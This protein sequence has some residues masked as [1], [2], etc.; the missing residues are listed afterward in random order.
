MVPVPVIVVPPGV[1]V[2]VH[3]PDDGSPLRVRDP[4]A[5]VHD[6]WTNSPAAGA[7]GVTGCSLIVMPVDAAEMQPEAFVTVNV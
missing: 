1:L 4:V 2:R 6:G 7:T 3:V 5:T